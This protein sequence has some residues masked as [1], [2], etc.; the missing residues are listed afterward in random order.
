MPLPWHPRQPC[1]AATLARSLKRP[2]NALPPPL[3]SP[4]N[5]SEHPL[6][7]HLTAL[8]AGNTT[9]HVCADTCP[10]HGSPRHYIHGSPRHTLREPPPDR[11]THPQQHP[12]HLPGHALTPRLP[13]SF[14]RIPPCTSPPPTLPLGKPTPSPP[15]NRTPLLKNT[16][17][18]S[19]SSADTA[20]GTGR[21]TGGPAPQM[22]VVGVCTWQPEGE[23]DSGSRGV[24]AQ[25]KAVLG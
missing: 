17:A 9:P 18:L 19:A 8:L 25:P 22:S 13:F 14:Q 7:S 1:H 20:A 23:S 6:G 4:C 2:L 10:F 24:V 12:S 3:Q 5:T 11:S 15:C 16:P 21:A